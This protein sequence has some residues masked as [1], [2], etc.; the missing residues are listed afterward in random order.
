MI[1]FEPVR[2]D[3]FNVQRQ[4]LT[5]KTLHGDPGQHQVSCVVHDKMKILVFAPHYDDEIIGNDN[6]VI[7]M[8]KR[9]QT[10]EGK[11]IYA[12]RKST[13]ET[14]FG[15]IKSTMGFRG[16]LRRSLKFVTEEW[17][18]VSIAW[19]IKRLFALTLSSCQ[20]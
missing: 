14:V 9:M 5:G 4:N 10:R 1:N 7:K 2:R 13:V 18:L 15:N 16:F 17:N 3:P 11:E 6:S 19:N 20:N 8:K 12:K